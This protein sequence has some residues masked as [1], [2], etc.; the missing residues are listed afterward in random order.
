[1]KNSKLLLIRHWKAKYENLKIDEKCVFDMNWFLEKFQY[2]KDLKEDK[3]EELQEHFESFIKKN[4]EELKTKNINL[5]ISPFA[6]TIQTAYIFLEKLKK[7]NIEI[8]KINLFSHLQEAENFSWE[9]FNWLVEWKEVFI[10]NKTVKFDKSITNPKNLTHAEYFFQSYWTKI[11][12]EYL[13]WLNIFENISSIET[14]DNIVKR[15]QKAIWRVLSLNDDRNLVIIFSH[16]CFSDQLIKKYENY[17]NGG[18]K[19]WEI[20]II[21][22][23][24]YERY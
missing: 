22:K 16:Q 12:K 10:N 15:S 19:E 18:Q 11:P 23:N 6:R 13:Q 2:T 4:L 3:I 20:L 17:K 24:S 5:W 14:Y 7:Y 1:M 9:V 8:N 21:K